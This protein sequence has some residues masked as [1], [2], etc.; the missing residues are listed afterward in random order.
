VKVAVVG[1]GVVGLCIAYDFARA[2]VDVVVLE[3]EACGGGASSGNAG[4]ITPV[5][6]APIPAPGVMTDAL[7]SMARSGS[8][9]ALRPQLRPA[10]WTW[11]WRFARSSRPDRWRSGLQAMLRLGERSMERFDELAGEGVA[12]EMHSEGMV[13]AAVTEAALEAEAELLEETTR[14]GYEHAI[15][16][17]DGDALR[18]LEPALTD[19]VVGGFH[20]PA[21][22]HVRPET[23]VR[24]LR[25]ALE[26]RGGTVTEHARVRGVAL[27][28]AGWRVRT[29]GADVL[30][31]RV[32]VAAG[33]S[34]AAILRSAGVRLALASAKGYSVTSARQPF[35][36]RRPLYLL[37]AKIA[38]SPFHG[39][40][41]LAGMFE[42]GARDAAVDP[43]RLAL[44]ARA[45]PRYLRDWS[46]D[47]RA[48]G[49][50]GLR[51]LAPDGLPYIGAVPGAPGLYAATGHGML[52]VTLA[53]ATSEALC[54]LVLDDEPPAL[55]GPFRLER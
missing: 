15:Q 42:L 44:L 28:S 31:D 33:A 25:D 22:R 27:E 40:L 38:C 16:A 55:L 26:A 20:I 8:P 14:A 9:L 17:L 45:A 1:G 43:R 41:R 37:E 2:G 5:L 24:G 23:F 29:E 32:V 13:F 50:A 18:A 48:Q 53:P 46:P 19:A 4:W 6:S 34:S 52:G 35:V 21:E 47:D 3:D 49:W 7:W 39:A 51:P 11:C 30:A 36:L 54:R 12:F 10:F